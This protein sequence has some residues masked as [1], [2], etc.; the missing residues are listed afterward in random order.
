MTQAIEPT[1]A[2]ARQ[3]EPYHGV[4]DEDKL[5]TLIGNM[6]LNGWQGAPV[7]AD[8]DCLITGAHRW[9]AVREIEKMYEVGKT[10]T[11]VLLHVVDIR[12]IYPEFDDLMDEFDNP[13]IGEPLYAQ[14][15]DSLPADIRD[16]YGIDVQ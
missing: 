12:D 10:D 4:H 11:E 1:T 7:V 16:T 9:H 6:V 14:A 3:Y 5:A 2:S 15:I 13:T 8:G